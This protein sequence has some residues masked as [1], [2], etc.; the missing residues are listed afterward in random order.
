MDHYY[1][2]PTE[3]ETVTPIHLK[4]QQLQRF[5][6]EYSDLRM[7]FLHYGITAHDDGLTV[8][9]SNGEHEL[10]PIEPLLFRDEEGKLAGFKEDGKGNIA[11]FSYSK[12]DSWSERLPERKLYA[13]VPDNHPYAKFIYY[14]QQQS[15]LGKEE[16]P[17]FRPE[18]PITRAEFVGQLMTL[19]GDPLSNEPSL[20]VDTNNHRYDS[21]IQTALE[22][23]IIK[24]TPGGRF[25]PNR[26]MT[27]QEAA[28]ALTRALL[29]GL[30]SA[31]AVPLEA[32]LKGDT[33]AW[34][35]KGV[36]N[37]VARGY[38]GPEVVKD[39]E[40]KVDYHS[41]QPMLRQEAAA[42]FYRFP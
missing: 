21:E 15:L 40:G 17:A 26:P 12:A 42:M 31:G 8:N 39:V 32:E 14:A 34:A 30:G 33:D 22:Y 36:E 25:E 24:G 29:I 35:I 41:K 19:A 18:E 28:M 1:P 11:Y 38:Y 2:K 7:K 4:R 13:D 3:T 27:R 10:I 20:F 16:E 23:G 6:G 5:E 37:V 9:D